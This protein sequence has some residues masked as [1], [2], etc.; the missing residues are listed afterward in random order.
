MSLT[1]RGRV[2]NTHFT[3]STWGQGSWDNDT[4]APC[5]QSL[6]EPASKKC[7]FPR[8]ACSCPGFGEALG[9]REL[10]PGS[11]RTGG[12]H[13]ASRLEESQWAAGVSYAMLPVPVKTVVYMSTIALPVLPLFAFCITSLPDSG[14]GLKPLS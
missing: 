3:Y 2:Q 11:W 9:Q 6:V 7:S 8:A 12:I 14:P 13:R 5:S 4:P 1:L 10:D